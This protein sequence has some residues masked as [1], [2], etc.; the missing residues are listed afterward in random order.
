MDQRSA[1]VAWRD[2]PSPAARQLD[3]LRLNGAD[4][5]PPR[6][7]PG[8]E[9]Q[10]TPVRGNGS[11]GARAAAAVD[12]SGAAVAPVDRGR[13]ESGWPFLLDEDQPGQAGPSTHNGG[14]L[15]PAFR[16][17]DD[18]IRG[19]DM[20][21]MNTIAQTSLSA[22]AA[23]LDPLSEAAIEAYVRTELPRLDLFC[24]AEHLAQLI[25]DEVRGRVIVR[26][27]PETGTG[28]TGDLGIVERAYTGNPSFTVA[29]EQ[30]W[31]AGTDPAR[32]QILLAAT[33]FYAFTTPEA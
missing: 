13:E 24:V 12:R 17:S 30:A 20:S 11:A 26:L 2:D 14:V 32:D 18:V 15:G 1:F 25:R 4:A 22:G 3:D 31:W 7:R 16:V 28:P 9:G 6:G 33:R 29:P 10:R 23:G 21:V 19:G 27:L 8:P 5:R